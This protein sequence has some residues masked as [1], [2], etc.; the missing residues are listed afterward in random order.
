[1]QQFL[2][3]Y[4][5]IKGDLGNEFFGFL[6]NSKMQFKQVF[7]FFDGISRD[8]MGNLL[9]L[10]GQRIGKGFFFYFIGLI[11][12]IF[13]LIMIGDLEKYFVNTILYVVLEEIQWKFKRN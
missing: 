12:L 2:V 11:C 8:R 9:V 6:V 3:V 5:I 1:M 10:G 4:L 7:F 13:Y